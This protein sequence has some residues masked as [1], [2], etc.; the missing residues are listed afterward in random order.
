MNTSVGRIDKLI[1]C[2]KLE[3]Q[4]NK[5][6]EKQDNTVDFTRDSPCLLRYSS[7]HLIHLI[8]LSYEVFWIQN[9]FYLSKKIES[10]KID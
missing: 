9:I 6:T 8:T 2:L 4:H 3:S 5:V 7:L 1:I 10:Q